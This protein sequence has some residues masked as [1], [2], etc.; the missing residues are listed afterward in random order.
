MDYQIY[1]RQVREIV[2]ITIYNIG[3]LVLNCVAPCV[4]ENGQCGGSQD[5]DSTLCCPP[6]TCQ[7]MNPWYSQCASESLPTLIPDDGKVL[8]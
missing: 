5:N 4:A 6:L 2:H 7:Y 8:N 1:Q 3:C